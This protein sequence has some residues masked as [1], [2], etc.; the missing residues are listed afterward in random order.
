ME[1]G[2]ASEEKDLSNTIERI[3]YYLNVAK[4]LGL[5]VVSINISQLESAWIV[6]NMHRLWNVLKPMSQVGQVAKYCH[7]EKQFSSRFQLESPVAKSCCKGF[8]LY[9]VT[10]S[11][12][13]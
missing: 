1:L 4:E 8:L 3:E 12:L 7:F 9:P 6:Q 5:K 13:L 11:I 10:T 2:F